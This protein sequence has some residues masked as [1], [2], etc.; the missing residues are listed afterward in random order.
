MKYG[1]KCKKI[2]EVNMTVK[3][4]EF[5]NFKENF[6]EKNKIKTRKKFQITEKSILFLFVGRLIKEKGIDLFVK[7]F[8]KALKTNKKIHLLIVGGGPLFNDLKN[9]I[10]G[11][12]NISLAGPLYEQDLLETYSSADIFVL[13]SI[14][15]PWGLVINEAMASSLPLLVNRNVGCIDD[16]IFDKENGIIFDF[17]N[18]N[19]LVESILFLANNKNIRDKMA[20][21]SK[22]TISNWTLRNQALKLSEGWRIVENEQI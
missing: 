5:M 3:V 9:S 8:K 18:H 17:K 19:Y 15:E 7:S 10:R 22:K 16:L 1:V 2:K 21:N 6:A 13:P 4:Q 14:I 20:L 11:Y 12:S